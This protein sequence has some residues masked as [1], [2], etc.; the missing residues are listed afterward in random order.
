[1][2]AVGVVK[3][4]LLRRA[5]DSDRYQRPAT[6]S[7]GPAG[8]LQLKFGSQRLRGADPVR[9][10][11]QLHLA[12][13]RDVLFHFVFEEFLPLRLIYVSFFEP[14]LHG[15]KTGERQRE[16]SFQ[17]TRLGRQL[18]L[19]TSLD[20]RLGALWKRRLDPCPSVLVEPQPLHT[21]LRPGEQSERCESSARIAIQVLVIQ[22]HQYD[23]L[24]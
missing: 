20:S 7:S 16:S 6:R 23:I 24:V 22:L 13:D 5:E 11:G 3:Q 18:Q 1:M 12:C 2:E 10:I 15:L 19:C 9:L 4:M 17:T 21:R 14:P 8:D